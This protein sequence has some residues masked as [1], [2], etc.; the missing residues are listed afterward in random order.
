LIQIRDVRRRQWSLPLQV[1]LVSGATL[2]LAQL[3]RCDQDAVI[4][5]FEARRERAEPSASENGPDDMI[6]A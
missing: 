4:A 3:G 5:A 2:R 6:G 1:D